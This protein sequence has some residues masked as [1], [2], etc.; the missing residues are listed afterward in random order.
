[1]SLAGSKERLVKSRHATEEG[2]M[3]GYI[4]AVLQAALGLRKAGRDLTVF[5]HDVFVV[6][7][8]KSGSTWSRFL[9][10]NL[11]EP[12]NPVTFENVERRVPAIYAW[13]DRVLRSWPRVLRSHES[14]D[15]RY[16][17]VLYLLRDPRDVAVS[18]YYHNVKL[19][20]FPDGYPMDDFVTHFIRADIA[21]YVDRF[22]CWEDHVLSWINVREGK[23][24]FCLTRY[25]DLQADPRAE[26]A[27]WMVLLGLHPTA[28]AIDQAI[29]LSSA[30]NMRSLEEKQSK[31]WRM[32]KNS[33]QDIRFI[34]DAKSGGWR[35]KLSERSVAAIEQAWAATMQKLGYELTTSPKLDPSKNDSCPSHT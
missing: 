21:P 5:P 8:P 35:N 23:P 4:K 10:G 12:D 31:Q 34:R 11:L 30:S 18:F 24:S 29:R 17:R 22:G 13:P 15:P 3:M 1:M 16:P 2:R 32:T 27:K 26:I 14:F 9:L 33:R 20:I 6:S 7:Y 19:R 28:E 25:E